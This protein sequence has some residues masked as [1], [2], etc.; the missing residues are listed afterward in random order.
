[1]IEVDVNNQFL[2]VIQPLYRNKN[3]DQ[4]WEGKISSIKKTINLKM[5]K[6]RQ[7]NRELKHDL[8]EKVDKISQDLL[9][10]QHYESA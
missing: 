2:F 4:N 8:F 5:N 1:M 9:E 7:E 3:S 10:K 6:L